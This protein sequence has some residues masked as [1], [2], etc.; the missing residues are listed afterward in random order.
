MTSP[1][2]PPAVGPVLAIPP[3]APDIE[4]MEREPLGVA[5]GGVISVRPHHEG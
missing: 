1:E 3:D 4:S 5:Q 2:Q